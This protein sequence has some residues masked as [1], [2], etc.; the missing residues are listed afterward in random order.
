MIQL[1]KSFPDK[2]EFIKF[3]KT[4][5]QQERNYYKLTNDIYKQII[6]K[7][8]IDSFLESIKPHYHKSKQFYLDRKLTY[9]KFVTL[10]RHICKK[11]NIT[12]TST[13]RYA[14]STYRIDYLIYLQDTD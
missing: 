14:N 13:M 6:F 12:Y 4:H 8:N 5:G 10:I 1:F 9:P 2:E 7:N 11:L 3:I